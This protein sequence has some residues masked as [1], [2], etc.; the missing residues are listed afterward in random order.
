LNIEEVLLFKRLLQ[1]ITLMNHKERPQD[2]KRYISSYGDVLTAIELLSRHTITDVLLKSYV[3]LKEAFR[4]QAFTKLQAMRVLRKSTTTIDRYI[5]LWTYLRLLKKSSVK[6]GNKHM[7][8]LLGYQLSTIPIIRK[9][10]Q[11]IGANFH[12]IS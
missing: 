2:N 9:L 4:E 7:Y 5:K 12:P 1:S 8:E 6:K 3:E 10:L 11:Q